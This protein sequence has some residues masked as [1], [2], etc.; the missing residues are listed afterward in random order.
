[1]TLPPSPTAVRVHQCHIL[2]ILAEK[3]CRRKNFHLAIVLPTSVKEHHQQVQVMSCR[4]FLLISCLYRNVLPSDEPSWI[5]PLPLPHQYANHKI[6]P[7]FFTART[8]ST[9]LRTW[10][11]PFPTIGS[12]PLSPC[13]PPSW[14]R[15]KKISIVVC[16]PIGKCFHDLGLGRHNRNFRSI[17]QTVFSIRQIVFVMEGSILVNRCIDHH[18]VCHFTG[19][20][21]F[22]PLFFHTG[23]ELVLIIGKAFSS[24][25]S[26]S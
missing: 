25:S 15:N 22:V 21:Y 16:I 8:L 26:V 9:I 19:T 3:H 18:V 11:T 6:C 4:F 23:L 17:C 24:R 1:M 10:N 5:R 2:S 20:Y 12:A 13:E 7:V 14:H